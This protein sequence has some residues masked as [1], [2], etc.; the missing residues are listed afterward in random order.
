MTGGAEGARGVG[1]TGS[2]EVTWDTGSDE[3]SSVRVKDCASWEFL[4]RQGQVV[5]VRT[6][7]TRAS[8]LS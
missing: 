2:A 3:A 4:D 6:F 7:S 8:S 5:E 1:P